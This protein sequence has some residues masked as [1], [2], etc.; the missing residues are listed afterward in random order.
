MPNTNLSYYNN[1]QPYR[2]KRYKY[3]LIIIKSIII[4]LVKKKNLIYNYKKYTI[5]SLE[6]IKYTV[7]L[8]V[9]VKCKTEYHQDRI[10]SC[11]NWNAKN[12]VHLNHPLIEDLMFNVCE[13][14]FPD[15][16]DKWLHYTKLKLKCWFIECN[17]S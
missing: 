5:I 6:L 4:Q 14:I 12:L 2:G 16:I 15:I 11:W 7:T 9:D 1:F 3:V 10:P 17:Y 13:P 8:L